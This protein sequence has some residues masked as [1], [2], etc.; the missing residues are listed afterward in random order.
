MS[1]RWCCQGIDHWRY[2]AYSPRVLQGTL[3]GLSDWLTIRLARRYWGPKV[4]A[5]T[6][7]IQLSM[8]FHM[9]CSVRTFSNSMEST[10]VMVAL[11]WWPLFSEGNLAPDSLRKA[12]AGASIAVMM[13]SSSALLWAYFLVVLLWGQSWRSRVHTIV[14]GVVPVGI[15]AVAVLIGL[16]WLAYGRIGFSPWN[17]VSF[18]LFTD[19]NTLFGSHPWYW[20]LTEGV[21]V[22][23]LSY[24]PLLLL[25]T[26]HALRRTFC[27]AAVVDR[28]RVGEAATPRADRASRVLVGAMV[29]SVLS[30][31]LSGHKEFRFLASTAYLGGILIAAYLGSCDAL[32]C[33]KLHA[34][35][36]SEEKEEERENM[37]GLDR[38]AASSMAFSPRRR[39]IRSHAEEQDGEASGSDSDR[40]GWCGR[41]D[42][43]G[44]KQDA[45]SSQR[46]GVCGGVGLRW[47][48][49]VA[50]MV[51]L[52][53]G[54]YMSI[55]HQVR[56]R[57]CKVLVIHPM[58]QRPQATHAAMRSHHSH[59]H[60]HTPP[61]TA[62]DACAIPA[63]MFSPCA[64][65]WLCALLSG[66]SSTLC[67]GWRTG[68]STASAP[69]PPPTPVI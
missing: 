14:S 60:A 23:F 66:E 12:L 69:A 3:A 39:R 59:N 19:F 34:E 29:W 65:Y 5:W 40:R 26:Y 51:Q 44:G 35:K 52:V 33:G 49:G 21:P 20:Y 1:K 46:R 7:L 57:A 48:V 62:M 50:A 24:T 13:R 36:F 10:F 55:V 17:F 9:F 68:R 30:L 42:T 63:P 41:R 56:G 43:D 37:E 2:Y 38:Q 15:G 27:A 58:C 31:S 6:A 18:N 4:A 47:V 45:G 8:W 28:R 61:C 16:D 54:G 25:A 32:A 53:F 64:G 22:V 67:T 11:Q